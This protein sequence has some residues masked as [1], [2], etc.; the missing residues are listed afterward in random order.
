MSGAASHHRRGSGQPP[1][2]HRT[3]PW[4]RPS[5]LAGGL[6]DAIRALVDDGRFEEAGRVLS[7][8][9]RD[10]APSGG[11][12]AIAESLRRLCETI[13]DH[14][15]RSDEL[16]AEAR[17]H[18]IAGEGLGE[19][20]DGLLTEYARTEAAS[21]PTEP[22]EGEAR[23]GRQGRLSGL[24]TAPPTAPGFPPVREP[25]EGTSP[26][27]DA[28]GPRTAP[29][30]TQLPAVL[31]IRMLGPLEVTLTHHQV[32][33]WR[34]AKARAVFQYLVFHADRPA[35]R[36]LLWDTFWPGHT[37]E[38]ARNNL[39]VAIH[40]LRRTLGAVSDRTCIVH[41][42]GRYSLEP[43]VPRWI[44]RDAFVDAITTALADR[45]AGHRDTAISGLG[46]AV[47]LYRGPLFEDDTASEWHLVDQ[48]HLED[49]YLRALDT[50]GELHLEGSAV[51][52]AA[53]VGQRA[54]VCDPC[55]ESSHRL[56]MRCYARQH[57]HHLVSR[58]LDLCVRT[59]RDRL[60]VPPAVETYRLFQQLTTV[61]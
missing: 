45:D 16:E 49:L 5:Q 39:N 30:G 38:S 56:L 26:P 3:L 43:G 27:P 2:L 25:R 8:S 9:R 50:L 19:V 32:E 28:A 52:T 51:D 15:R 54:L 41:A 58:Q 46:R 1:T 4:L 37:R 33:R 44:D 47:G 22:V 20:L 48:R 18:R 13:V 23:G 6:S 61:R 21:P 24:S 29:T 31:E 53:E 59:L 14:R 60:G 11:A 17:R 12:D 7:E 36:E 55:R 34:S 57:Q 40:N 35:R 10:D 42:D